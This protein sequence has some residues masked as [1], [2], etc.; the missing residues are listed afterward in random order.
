MNGSPEPR[1]SK[2]EYAQRGDEMYERHVLPNVGPEDKGKFAVVDIETGDYEID[3]DDLTATHRLLAR[4]PGAQTWLRR[5]G[6][7][8][9]YRIRSLQSTVPAW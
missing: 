8:Y 4:R 7:R 5:V 9:A 3:A 2:E 6:S 1:L